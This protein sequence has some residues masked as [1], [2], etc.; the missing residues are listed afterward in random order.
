MPEAQSKSMHMMDQGNYHTFSK[1]NVM[2]NSDSQKR[3]PEIQMNDSVLTS[4]HGGNRSFQNVE[5]P[6]LNMQKVQSNPNSTP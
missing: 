2:E 3:E 1:N 6:S 4:E 5:V